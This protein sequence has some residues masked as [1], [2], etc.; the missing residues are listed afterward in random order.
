M[1]NANAEKKSKA[2]LRQP[3]TQYNVCYILKKKKYVTYAETFINKIIKSK[4][5]IV[6]NTCFCGVYNRDSKTSFYV[7][8]FVAMNTVFIIIMPLE[9]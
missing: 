1:L 6:N 2:K 4:K 5:T 8:L 9:N 3:A 7:A